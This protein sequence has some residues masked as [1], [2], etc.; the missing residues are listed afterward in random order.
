MKLRLPYHA[1]WP[2]RPS[3]LQG[4]RRGGFTI[5][6]PVSGA[7]RCARPVEGNRVSVGPRHKLQD[8]PPL[9]AT[10]HQVYGP[11]LQPP[12]TAVSANLPKS[13]ESSPRGAPP[14]EA[15]AQS[16]VLDWVHA[17]RHTQPPHAT[18]TVAPAPHPPSR[19]GGDSRAPPRSSSALP[20]QAL[21]VRAPPCVSHATFLL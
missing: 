10:V 19:R 11:S 2:F 17:N 12:L 6:W 20:V 15:A 14:A 3:S 5:R 7:T 4:W 18:S 16:P 21:A 9:W 1:S 8:A 13:L